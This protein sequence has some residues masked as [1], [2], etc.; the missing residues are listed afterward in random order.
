M[1]VVM[2]GTPGNGL[3]GASGAAFGSGMTGLGSKGSPPKAFT[4]ALE[5]WHRRAEEDKLLAKEHK[6][7]YDELQTATLKAAD[8]K[9]KAE[10]KKRATANAA[11]VERQ[12]GFASGASKE[13]SRQAVLRDEALKKPTLGSPEPPWAHL[14]EKAMVVPDSWN[15]ATAKK[16]P[17]VAVH[18]L[19]AE[20]DEAMDALPRNI[21]KETLLSYTG[22][23]TKNSRDLTDKWTEVRRQ[24][25]M[26]KATAAE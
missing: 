10:A 16:Y 15:W 9:K 14:A 22:M 18:G 25:D 8:L 26:E 2:T 20:H 19:G 23:I 5:V 4:P 21:D 6:K 17:G 7:A 24:Q 11:F 3:G 1:P 12:K 13:R